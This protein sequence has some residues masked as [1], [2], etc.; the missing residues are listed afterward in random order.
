MDV[1]PTGGT[2][3]VPHVSTGAPRWLLAIGFASGVAPPPMMV[4]ASSSPQNRV[5]GIMVPRAP[6]KQPPSRPLVRW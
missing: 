4:C 3:G 5:S 6:I 2:R 1:A